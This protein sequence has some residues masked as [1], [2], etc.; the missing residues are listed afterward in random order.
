MA[1]GVA[2]PRAQGQAISNTVIALLKAKHIE[3]DDLLLIRPGE[4]IPT[5][6][7]VVA[8]LSTVDEAM[9]TGESLPV[10]KEAGHKVIGGCVNG[11]GVLTIKATAIG[12]DTVL[13]G[14]IHMVDQAQAS[15]LPVQKLVDK[16]SAIFVPSVMAVSALTFV[17]HN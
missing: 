7:E 2:K 15:K 1:V 16:I 12:M 8:G 14:I 13:A 6:G 10:V 17:V 11:T 4:K 9:V 3:L 5:D